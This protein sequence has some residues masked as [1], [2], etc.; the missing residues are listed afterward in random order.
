MLEGPQERVGVVHRLAVG[1]TDVAALGQLGERAERGRGTQPT[2]G[3]AVHELQ[4]LDGELHVA[5]P[6]GPELELAVGVLRRDVLDDATPHGLHVVDESVALGGLPHERLHHLGVLA[7]DREV[8][9]HR[10]GLEQRLELPGLGPA[11][12]VAAVAGDGADERGRTCPRAAGW[13]RPARSCPRRCGRS[14]PASGG[15]PAGWRCARPRRPRRRRRARRRRSR[16][17]R[18]RS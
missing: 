15:S 3:A 2:V 7:P 6:A 18:R 8:A 9:R 1:A 11:L 14:R 5:Q 16:R 17:R 4:Q 13:R 10:P 12:V